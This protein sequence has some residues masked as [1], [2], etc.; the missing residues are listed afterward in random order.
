MIQLLSRLIVLDLDRTAAEHA[1]A[2]RDILASD[3]R[4]IGPCDTVI[5]GQRRSLGL[6][7][8]TNN[9]ERFRRVSE[10]RLENWAE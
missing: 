9:I 5:A 3:G 1:D 2:I 4:P 8:I 7:L 6:V 10:L